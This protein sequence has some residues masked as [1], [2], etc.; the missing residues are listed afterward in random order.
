M[1]GFDVEPQFSANKNK[2]FRLDFNSNNVNINNVFKRIIILYSKFQVHFEELIVFPMLPG[3]SNLKN[4]FLVLPQSSHP[5][6]HLLSIENTKTYCT[7]NLL[8]T[9]TVSHNHITS[10]LMI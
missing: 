10:S 9:D 2:L 5:F 8:L 7:F 6:S 3:S 1:L 4:D